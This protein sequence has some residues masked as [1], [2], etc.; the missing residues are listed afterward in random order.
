M[1]R[2]AAVALLVGVPP[3]LLLTKLTAAVVSP[4]VPP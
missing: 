4:A 1:V 2:K 3:W